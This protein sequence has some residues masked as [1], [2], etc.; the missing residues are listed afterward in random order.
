MLFSNSEDILIVDII[1][2]DSAFLLLLLIEKKM[3][4]E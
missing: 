3:L 2:R 1:V 4:H